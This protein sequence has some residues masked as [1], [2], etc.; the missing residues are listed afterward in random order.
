MKSKLL[1]FILLFASQI[2]A[3]VRN[4]T[5]ESSQNRTEILDQLVDLNSEQ[6]ARVSAIYKDS[7]Q[8]EKSVNENSNFSD[9]KKREELEKIRLEEETAL[10]EIL[11]ET[12][13]GKLTENGGS[14]P[15]KANINTSRSN[16]K[17]QN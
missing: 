17:Q 3:Q 6:E 8:K 5:K 7:E 4:S 9:T 14:E 10:N 1:L 2:N 12:Q 15:Q 11:T 13:K 16:I